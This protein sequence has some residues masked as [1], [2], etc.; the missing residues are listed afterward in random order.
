M[1]DA[2]RDTDRLD[3]PKMWALLDKYHKAGFALTE[4]HVIDHEGCTCRLKGSAEHYSSA[5]KHPIRERWQ[6]EPLIAWPDIVATWEPRTWNVGILTG[7]VSGI[8]VLDVDPAGGGI[9][10]LTELQR[11]HGPLPTT[12]MVR[13]GGGGVHYYWRLPGWSAGLAAAVTIRNSASKRAGRGLDVRGDGGYVVTAPSVSAKGSY[14]VLADVPIIEAPAWLVELVRQPDA[15]TDTLPPGNITRGV[16]QNGHVASVALEPVEARRVAA[17]ADSAVRGEIGRLAAAP[18]GTRNE[19]AFAVACNLIELCNS[20]WSGWATGS[21]YSAYVDAVAACALPMDEGAACWS[22]AAAKVGTT[23]RALPVLPA[24]VGIVEPP[25]VAPPLFSAPASGAGA[26]LAMIPIGDAVDALLAEFLDSDQLDDITPLLPL[27]GG[28]LWRDTVG[29][30]TGQ[31]GSMKSFVA[32]SMACAVAA[33]HPWMGFPVTQGD[34]WYMVA[35]GAHGVRPRLRAW[36]KTHLAGGRIKH[37]TF[38]P[39]PVQARA[40]GEWALLVEGARRRAPALIVLDTQARITVGAE[41]NS[42][43]DMGEFVERADELRRASGATVLIV[44][45]LTKDGG[46]MRGSGA[47]FGAAQTELLTTKEIRGSRTWV[48]VTTNKQK[49]SPELGPLQLVP[50]P[51]AG[52]VEAIDGSLVGVATKGSVVLVSALQTVSPEQVAIDKAEALNTSQS[53]LAEIMQTTFWQLPGGTRGEIKTE[54]ARLGESKSTFYRVFN[55]LY[56]RGLIKKIRGTGSYIWCPPDLAVKAAKE[57][58]Y[59]GASSNELGQI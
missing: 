15:P 29:W 40:G 5:G 22:S 45:H 56:T 39:R 24:L 51:V 9:E 11:V 18:V 19:T 3:V 53:R 6:R 36:E 54:W 49:D 43:K 12:F 41:E 58:S 30:L 14:D 34:V 32:L 17:Y 52:D 33:G 20:P 2:S 13:T 1:D 35:E 4:L 47:M 27:I 16:E 46:S 50:Q 38:L 57:D 26:G 28:Y 44:H 37:L 31:P 42:A 59:F 55:D 10:T 23:A 8:W 25:A 21:A 7:S 48:T